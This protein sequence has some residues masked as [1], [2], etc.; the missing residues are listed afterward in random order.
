MT[1]DTTDWH[2]GRSFGDSRFL[3][4]KCPCPKAPCGLVIQGQTDPECEHHKPMKTIR[5]A[6]APDK[7]PVTT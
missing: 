2:Y 6:H 4:E 1:F 5:Q 7:C 3:E